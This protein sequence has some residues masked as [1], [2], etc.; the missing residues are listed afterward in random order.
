[1]CTKE[2]YSNGKRVIIKNITLIVN[3]SILLTHN[4]RKCTI[5]TNRYNILRKLYLE[6]AWY[7]LCISM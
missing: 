5:L 3:V 1:M 7:L 2:K 6:S 4:A